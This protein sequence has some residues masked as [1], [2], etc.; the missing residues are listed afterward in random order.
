M[1]L[2]CISGTLYCCFLFSTASKNKNRI[3]IVCVI[4][5]LNATN[6]VHCIHIVGL[7]FKNRVLT[8]LPHY[9]RHISTP[10]TLCKQKQLT[11]LTVNHSL[12]SV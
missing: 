3:L 5:P 12:L 9:W 1:L 7:V 4:V 8:F 6:L 11:K 10:H 2:K